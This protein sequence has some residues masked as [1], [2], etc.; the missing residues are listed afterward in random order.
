MSK[1]RLAD[2]YSPYLR[3]HAD[4]PVDWYPWG[5]EALARARREG[6]PILLSIGYSA[7][8]W[9][10]VMAHESFEDAETAALMN[11]HFINIKVDREERPDLDKI[12]QTAH[13]LL[14]RRPGG[15]PLTVFLMPEDHTPFFAGTY[16]PKG[17]HHGL[18]PF[19]T[20]LQRVAEAFTH[21]RGPIE[22]QNQALRHA[23]DRLSPRGADAGP[24]D[25]GPLRAAAEFLAQ[26]FDSASGGFGGA[27]RFPHVESHRLLLR[28]WAALGGAGELYRR[29]V[30]HSLER[31]AVSGICDQV[32][33]G[34]FRYSVDAEWQ[35][36]H[37]EKMLYDNGLLLGLYA[38]LVALDGAPL[39]RDAAL[40]IADWA[41]REMQAP[42]GGFYSSLD[43]DTEGHEGRFYLWTPE[44]VRALLDE[45]EY[46]LFARC[47]G[48]DEG[49]NFEGQWHLHNGGE[50]CAAEAERALLQGARAKLLAARAGR[51]RPGR[52]DKQLTAW[53]ALLIEGLA[54]AG[55]RLQRPELIDIA[56]QALAFVRENLWRNGR[57]LAVHQGGHSHLPAYLDDHAYLLAALL[58][59]LQARWQSDHLAFAIEL[60]EQLL[61]RFED[62]Q[63][64][65]FFFTAHDHERLIHRPKP[66]ADESL[67]A[68]NGVAALA[69]LRLGHL[70]GEPRY[71]GAAERT[72][73]SAWASIGD[74][75][76]AH[77]TLLEALEELLEAPQ[78]IVLRGPPEEMAQ[79]QRMAEASF[80][81]RRLLFAIP[82]DAPDLPAALAE[83]RAGAGT[84]AYLCRGTQCSPPLHD[85][86]AF[87]EALGR[88][89][90]T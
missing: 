10:H 6:K 85:L 69:L 28:Q 68:G 82:S 9:C 15:W 56:A 5:E 41:R 35:I 20:V 51:I 87:D 44:A 30:E 74:H 90:Q 38:D 70:L 22:E 3:Q 2:S 26:N 4:N 66:Y 40:G 37:F 31:M 25:A 49:P 18:L 13:Q 59:L 46:L 58:E 14:A 54:R 89:L 63:H 23:L 21:Q 52:D 57:L 83:K 55:R 62:P 84:I 64:G 65:G 88:P 86:A 75:P 42:N 19:R 33:G 47:Y 27:P 24:L 81:P 1:N 72:L 39:F 77:C 67:P 32:G 36:P 79:W 12:Y 43:A 61:D 60:A 53:N 17:H 16:F 29:M 45:R 7:C 11:E 71:L 78:L 48:L 50:P 34:F 8:H 76:Q 80:A 73:R